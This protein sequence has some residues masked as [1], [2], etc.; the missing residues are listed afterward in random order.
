MVTNAVNAARFLQMPNLLV[1][2]ERAGWAN[3]DAIYK[4]MPQMQR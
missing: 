1:S 4:E 2:I 3:I